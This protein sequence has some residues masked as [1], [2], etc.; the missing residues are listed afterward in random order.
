MVHRGLCP[1]FHSGPEDRRPVPGREAHSWEAEPRVG[2]LA[3]W[4]IQG[5]RLDSTTDTLFS[6]TGILGWGN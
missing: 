4:D 6:G 1:P 5:A 3:G 2:R